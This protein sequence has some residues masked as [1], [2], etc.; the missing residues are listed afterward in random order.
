MQQ[1]QRV[2]PK[3][4]SI[5]DTIEGKS[6]E[7]SHHFPDGFYIENDLLYHYSPTIAP[8]YLFSTYCIGL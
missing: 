8:R 1:L 6:S 2:D 7:P 5:I 3:L 4:K